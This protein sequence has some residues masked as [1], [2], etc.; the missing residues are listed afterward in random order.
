MRTYLY[1]ANVR[2]YNDHG[3]GRQPCGF[4]QVQVRAENPFFAKQQLIAQYGAEN[5]SNA[6]QIP[7]TEQG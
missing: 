4:M 7:N 1:W 6:N 3:Y 5:V 2:T